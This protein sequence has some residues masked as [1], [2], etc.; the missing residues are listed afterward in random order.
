MKLIIVFTK[1]FLA[2][3][4]VTD[5]NVYVVSL[6]EYFPFDHS[7]TLIRCTWWCVSFAHCVRFPPFVRCVTFSP[8]VTCVRFSP[9][10]TCVKFAS[11]L[12]CVRFAS[13]LMCLRFAS[14]V[15]SNFSTI[16]ELETF[17]IIIAIESWYS[18]AV[19][20]SNFNY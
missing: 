8:C 10:V 19:W 2:S 12:R 13:C 3:T 5:Y 1:K 16:F 17:F 14:C 20:F 7:S 18:F 6:F 11:C 9:C 15:T 4:N